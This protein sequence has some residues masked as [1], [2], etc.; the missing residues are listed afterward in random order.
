[1][2]TKNNKTNKPK[3]VS[4]LLSSHQKWMKGEEENGRGRYC[5]IGAINMCYS[6]T[7]VVRNKVLQSIRKLFP[8]GYYSDIPDFN[9]NEG[10]TFK[11]IQKVIKHAKV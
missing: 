7:T 9:D 5:L 8:K 1:M 2:K 6:N 11:D 10:T 4:Q 3:K